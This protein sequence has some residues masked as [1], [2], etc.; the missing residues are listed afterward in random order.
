MRGSEWIL[1]LSQ[2]ISTNQS[3]NPLYTHGD[4]SFGWFQLTYWLFIKTTLHIRDSFWEKK[5]FLSRLDLPSKRIM[6]LYDNNANKRESHLF[7]VVKSFHVIFFSY[8]F[9]FIILSSFFL[10]SLLDGENGDGYVFSDDCCCENDNR[11]LSWRCL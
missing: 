7:F 1:F 8:F 3:M 9:Y 11:E 6:K 2:L 4:V 5:L 10:R